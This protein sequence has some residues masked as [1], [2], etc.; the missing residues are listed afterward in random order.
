M[1]NSG[2]RYGIKSPT[3]CGKLHSIYR[4]GLTG[5][6][7]VWI[8]SDCL[9]VA[10]F[11]DNGSHRVLQGYHHC[12]LNSLKRLWLG[13]GLQ[14]GSENESGRKTGLSDPCCLS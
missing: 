13:S 12:H 7:I 6:G 4:W 5:V 14:N 8:L 11:L 2:L 3:Q 1:L 10:M 9:D